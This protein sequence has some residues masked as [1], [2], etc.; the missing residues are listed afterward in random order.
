MSNYE[1]QLLPSVTGKLW[2]IAAL[3]LV[4]LPHLLRMPVWLSLACIGIFGW[5]L[6]HEMKGWSLPRRPLRMAITLLAFTAVALLFKTVIG[7]DAGVALLSVML[8][9]KLLELR[10]LRDAMITLY[11]GYFLV[12]CAF[13]FSQSI[14][15]GGYLLLV[16]LL[17]TAALIA[18]NHPQSSSA[19]TRYYL[20]YSGQLLLQAFPLMPVLN[21]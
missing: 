4:L 20:R 13:L 9:L 19:N 11:L 5:R 15:T 17:L 18:L 3:F 16:V 1:K 21:V 7:R 10:T 2:L 14:Y 8:C 6:A 12:I